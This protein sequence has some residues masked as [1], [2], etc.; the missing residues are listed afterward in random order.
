[1]IGFGTW[2]F[3]PIELTNPFPKGEGT[4]HLWQGD[5][6]RLVPV[7]PIR[8]IGQQHSWIQ[9]HEIPG[10]GHLFPYNKGMSEAILKAQLS[11]QN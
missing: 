8:Y 5:D 10:A 2:E 3:D 4:V 1:M 6:D 11:I 7:E 9:Y